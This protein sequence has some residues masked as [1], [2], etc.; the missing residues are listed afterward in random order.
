M[1]LAE[2][3]AARIARHSPAHGGGV[4]MLLTSQV[5]VAD[6]PLGRP[7]MRIQRGDSTQSHDRMYS[8]Q[9]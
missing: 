1:D 7:R 5:V 4:I 6:A 3:R 2:S 9:V 8:R